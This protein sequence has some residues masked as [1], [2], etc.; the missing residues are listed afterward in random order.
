MYLDDILFWALGSGDSATEG[1]DRKKTML[2]GLDS[3]GAP[4]SKRVNFVIA[5]TR[6]SLLGYFSETRGLAAST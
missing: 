6:V 1:T 5:K 3:E 4:I 2:E